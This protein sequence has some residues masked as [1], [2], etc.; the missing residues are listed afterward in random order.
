VRG[1]I[2]LGV[3]ISLI[4]TGM[5]LGLFLKSILDLE[6]NFVILIII[7]CILLTG[8]AEYIFGRCY[9]KKGMIDIE[10]DWLTKRTPVFKQLLK[11]RY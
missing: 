8:L 1:Q 9:D 2:E 10:N 11:G 3:I 7:G 6:T 5:L 4:N